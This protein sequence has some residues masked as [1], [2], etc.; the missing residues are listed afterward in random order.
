MD[1]VR[2][3]QCSWSVIEK[4]ITGREI[5]LRKFKGKCNFFPISQEQEEWNRHRKGKTISKVDTV[6]LFLGI[7]DIIEKV[8]IGCAD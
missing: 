5:E 6:Q 4:V 1:T 3:S 8:K 2:L 7:R